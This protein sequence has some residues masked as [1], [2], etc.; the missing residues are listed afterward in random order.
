M[1]KIA[2]IVCFILIPFGCARN[3]YPHTLQGEVKNG[4]YTTK[5]GSGARCNFR[6]MVPQESNQYATHFIC[7]KEFYRKKYSLISFGPSS[8]DDTIYRIMIVKNPHLPLWVF[9]KKYLPLII[10]LVAKGYERHLNKIHEE[11]I[12]FQGHETIYE[13]FTQQMESYD[14]YYSRNQPEDKILTHAFYF[15]NYGPYGIIFW[16]QASN[17][18]PVNAVDHRTRWQMINRVWLPQARFMRSFTFTGDKIGLTKLHYYW[19]CGT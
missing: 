6:V 7:T 16:I 2:W 19:R 17:H 12:L 8:T 1:K 18:S 5:I 9:K 11:P 10:D 3:F 4:T 15:V 13:V 14:Y